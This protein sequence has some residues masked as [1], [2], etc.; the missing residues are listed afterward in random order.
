MLW[1]LAMCCTDRMAPSGQA[2]VRMAFHREHDGAGIGEWIGFEVTRTHD[3]ISFGQ[4]EMIFHQHKHTTAGP[5][6]HL[7]NE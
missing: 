4:P 7:R 2:V 1:P 3:I 5:R 6:F